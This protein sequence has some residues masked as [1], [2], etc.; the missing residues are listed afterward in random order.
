MITAGRSVPVPV[1]PGRVPFHLPIR[2]QI[3]S[4][5]NKPQNQVRIE[6]TE[7]QKKQIRQATGKEA[8][9]VE[10]KVDELEDRIAPAVFLM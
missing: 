4:K 2:R 3:M 6:L 1:T 7:E 9:A 8:S 10:F 5:D